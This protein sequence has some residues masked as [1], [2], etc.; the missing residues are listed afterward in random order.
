MLDLIHQFR[1]LGFGVHLDDFGTGYSSLSRLRDLP[2]TAIKLDRTFVA[3]IRE[4]GKGKAFLKSMIRMARELDLEIVAEG[5]ETQE[6]A[7]FL[8]SEG[9][10]SVQ[11]WLYA[12]AM[13][14]DAFFAWQ[15][16][17]QNGT[18][19]PLESL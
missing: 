2:L 3:D 10:E 16:K 12:A 1:N 6:Q 4:T 14:G 19:A 8:R 13:P 11:G 17:F 15:E 7:N 9:V 5:V 18:E